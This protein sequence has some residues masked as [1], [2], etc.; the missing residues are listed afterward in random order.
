[1]SVE[2]KL[3]VAYEDQVIG[4][5]TEVDD[6]FTFTYQ[7]SWLASPDTFDIGPQFTRARTVIKGIEVKNFLENLLPE[8]ESR[9]KIAK[10]NKID[11]DDIVRL[12]EITGRDSAGALQIFSEK[13][14]AEFKYEP[15]K[16]RTMPIEELSEGIKKSGGGINFITEVGLKPSLSGAQDK[17]A[18]RYDVAA[19]IIKFPLNGG[20]T[21]HILK[22]GSRTDEKEKKILETSALNEYISM[23]LAKKVIQNTPETYFY[24]SKA[25][26]LYAIERYD[27]DVVGDKI[28][29]IHQFDFCQYFGLSSKDKYEVSKSGSII[30][31]YGLKQ[32]IE[33][34]R[35]E[36]EN[37]QDVDKIY[38]WVIFNYLI[39]NT[40]SH[41]K[42]LSMISTGTGFKLAPFYDIT[43]VSFYQNDGA[44]IYDNHF[45]FLVGGESAMN[46]LCD[47]EWIKY[48]K[49]LGLSPDFF[50]IR[51]RD[52]SY[53]ISA[54]LK[55]VYKEVKFEIKDAK[56]LKST[57]KIL[58]FIGT[59]MEEKSIR[60]LKNTKLRTKD[61]KCKICGTDLLKDS[62]LN[63]GTECLK[64]LE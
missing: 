16:V 49:D 64:K 51:I 22:P 9:E 47:R 61:R 20:A 24:E 31:D 29:R 30:G 8:Q 44:F 63:I 25:R 10:N 17:I 19:G 45:A 39:G 33:G 7:A 54:A 46:K 27:R 6:I 42:N 3:V 13:E 62:V 40:D 15:D 59:L 57:E 26:E 36:S 56:N 60:C 35:Q 34:I 4:H 28:K 50:L 58:K 14:F 21:T 48:A 37:P 55:E 52:M 12:L 1:M 2:R 23:R 11:P 18:C 38:D 41:L 53:K 32:I 43:S 5:V